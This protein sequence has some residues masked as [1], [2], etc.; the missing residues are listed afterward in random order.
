LPLIAAAQARQQLPRPVTLVMF[1]RAP[2]NLE[3]WCMEEICRIREQGSHADAIHALCQER[4]S[5]RNDDWLIAAMELGLIGHVVT[6]G[7]EERMSVDLREYKD[8]TG[9]VHYLEYPELPREALQ[10]PG[11]LCAVDRRSCLARLWRILGWLPILPLGFAMEPQQDRI[12]FSADLGCFAVKWRGYTF[13]WPEAVF[14]GEFDTPSQ[15]HRVKGMTGRDLVAELLARAG[16]IAIARE[17]N[18]CGGDANAQEIME[19]V[20]H[21][22]FGDT[23]MKATVP[24][25]RAT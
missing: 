20:D 8:H 15:D 24:L 12:L 17:P 11:S 9:V 3:P 23:L 16:L 21:Y 4:L 7:V 1:D 10:Y 22:L 13:P 18:Q 25:S 14:K 19:K 2:D 6:F 5:P